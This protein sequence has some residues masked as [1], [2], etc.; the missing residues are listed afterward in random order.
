MPLI[1]KCASCG[2][3]LYQGRELKSVI[4]IL[5]RWDFRCPCCF[6]KLQPK[7]LDYKIEL[8]DQPSQEESSENREGV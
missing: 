1:I 8:A 3:I 4:D 6:S 2:F 5:K 7:I